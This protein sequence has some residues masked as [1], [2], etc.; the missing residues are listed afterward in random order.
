MNTT[1]LPKLL[2]IIE[3][4]KMERLFST[5]LSV[6]HEYIDISDIKVGCPI[7]EEFND[8]YRTTMEYLDGTQHIYEN[9]F[10]VYVKCPDFIDYNVFK[11]FVEL[12]PLDD[13]HLA[14][15]DTTNAILYDRF[16]T[17]LLDGDM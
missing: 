2:V 11:V 16:G 9:E 13:F 3:S 4:K 14:G 1:V 8:L 6:Y 7:L 10:D 15:L 5:F 17:V 12:Y